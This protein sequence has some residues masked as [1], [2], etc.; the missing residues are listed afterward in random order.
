MGYGLIKKKM[1]LAFQVKI[2]FKALKEG[3]TVLDLL[4]VVLI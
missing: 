3:S 4:K 1:V 2:L